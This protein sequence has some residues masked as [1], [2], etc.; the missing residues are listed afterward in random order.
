NFDQP[1]QQ[2]EAQEVPRELPLIHER[3]QQQRPQENELQAMEME[4]R[5]PQI[6]VE[7]EH[8]DVPE[9]G[10]EI[11]VVTETDALRRQG[12]PLGNGVAS[13]VFQDAGSDQVALPDS[14]SQDR[15]TGQ[16]KQYTARYKGF[17]QSLDRPLAKLG[18]IG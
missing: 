18:L 17:R 4:G 13:N 7:Q 10:G 8:F 1:I 15:R 14:L 2:V 12:R 3:I 9:I 5:C 6:E 16:P 11:E